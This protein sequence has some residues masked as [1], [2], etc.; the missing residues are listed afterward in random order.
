MSGQTMAAHRQS[1]TVRA[2]KTSNK[3]NVLEASVT[4]EV[5]VST[6]HCFSHTAS[7]SVHKCSAGFRGRAG[8]KFIPEAE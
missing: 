2:T 3:M 6:G 1:Q 8:N 4:K 7:A 5:A